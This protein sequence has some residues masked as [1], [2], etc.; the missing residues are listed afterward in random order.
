[1]N[2]T[3]KHPTIEGWYWVRS[4]PCRYSGKVMTFLQYGLVVENDEADET[5]HWEDHLDGYD[6]PV[7]ADPEGTQYYG[8]I[9]APE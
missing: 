7:T 8:P 1:M 9:V 3:T 4:N 6:E 5:L 2:W